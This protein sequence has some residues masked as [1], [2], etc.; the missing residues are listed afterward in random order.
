MATDFSPEY[1]KN[2]AKTLRFTPLYFRIKLAPLIKKWRLLRLKLSSR[3]PY[4]S[5]A[6][7]SITSKFDAGAEHFQK[8]GWV[9]IEEMIAPDFHQE[10]IRNWPKKYYLEPP[11]ELAKSYNTGFRWVY[12]DP[13][14]LKYS[15]PHG[16][17]PT[18]T[19]FL[20]YLRQPEFA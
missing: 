15:D 12:G 2:S 4:P 5:T 9:F 7:C 16:Q 17:Y 1:V 3:R 6:E 11:R 20:N 19:K 13:Q 10:M 14:D 18:L 8:E